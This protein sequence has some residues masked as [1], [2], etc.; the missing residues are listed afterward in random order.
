MLFRVRVRVEG[1]RGEI[2][3]GGER[4]RAEGTE[5]VRGERVR[6]EGRE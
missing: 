1:W 2:E 3:G 5:G 6:V 4:V